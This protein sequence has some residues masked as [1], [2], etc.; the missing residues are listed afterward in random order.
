MPVM[1]SGAY[2]NCHGKHWIP[3]G[4]GLY[5]GITP[6]KAESTRRVPVS[7]CHPEAVKKSIHGSRASPRTDFCVSSFKHLAVRPELCRRATAIFFTASLHP[8][9]IPAP[10]SAL[11]KSGM[12]T[13]E[14]LKHAGG[15]E[16][17]RSREF[18]RHKT[19]RR[20][21]TSASVRS[22]PERL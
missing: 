18:I 6:R 22:V 4:D 5:D 17:G 13:G 16:H 2:R 3:K 9:A 1:K 11:Q 19:L 20:Y 12:A 10:S 15:T 8:R 21:P 7:L 14:K